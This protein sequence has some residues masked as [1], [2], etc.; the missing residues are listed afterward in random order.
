MRVC[1]SG[2]CR[3]D[4]YPSSYLIGQNER[5]LHACAAILFSLVFHYNYNG[6][7]LMHEV[8]R[9]GKRD[10]RIMGNQSLGRAF[11]HT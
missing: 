9:G 11:L 10:C 1:N 7:L 8:A 6:T 2:E 4:T 3:L 5:N